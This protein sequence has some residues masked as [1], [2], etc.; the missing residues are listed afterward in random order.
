MKMVESK[1]RSSSVNYFGISLLFAAFLAG[2]HAQTKPQQNNVIDGLEKDLCEVNPEKSVS[3]END[4]MITRNPTTPLQYELW[5][6]RISAAKDSQNP[7]KRQLEQIIQQVRSI[8]IKSKTREPEPVIET[9]AEADPNETGAGLKPPSDQMLAKNRNKPANGTISEQT[10]QRFK[11][12]SQK[13]EQLNNPLELAEILFRCGCLE[14]AAACFRTALNRIH[15]KDDPL[16]DKAW[17]LLQLGNCL[18][19][20]NPQAAIENY[21][22]VIAEFPYSPWAK[23]AKAKSDSVSWYLKD[24]PDVLIKESNSQTDS[25][26]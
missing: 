19:N 10:L 15:E 16:Q 22:A 5:K 11:E 17:I 3:A 20:K 25:K 18:K 2:A 8:E 12:L 1:K 9:V 26:R 23:V 7:A 4:L 13:P 14:E 6:A 21:Q 24:Q